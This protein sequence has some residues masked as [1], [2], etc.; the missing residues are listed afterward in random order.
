M[1]TLLFIL[2]AAALALVVTAKAW[3]CEDLPAPK[4]PVPCSDS[5]YKQ[6]N[7]RASFYPTKL[8]FNSTC[9]SAKAPFAC[10]AV[11][12]R[13][14]LQ[15]PLAIPWAADGHPLAIPWGRG[16]LSRDPSPGPGDRH[17]LAIP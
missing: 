2:C 4:L 12:D 15:H 13:P 3:P 11:V 7:V 14:Y 9:T 17:P 5:V 1:T 16:P 10:A 6:R 8:C